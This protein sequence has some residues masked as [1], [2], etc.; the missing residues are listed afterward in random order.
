MS[1]FD[2][3]YDSQPLVIIDRKTEHRLTWEAAMQQQAAEIAQRDAR[4]AELEAA[5]DNELVVSHLGVFNS[6]DDPKIALNKLQCYEQDLG[7]FFAQDQLKQQSAEITRLK[8]LVGKCKDGIEGALSDDLPYINE[9]KEALASI[10][11]EIL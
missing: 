2:D 6:G 11:E 3:W 4:I 10:K 1:A 9:C 5:I 8:A 7:A